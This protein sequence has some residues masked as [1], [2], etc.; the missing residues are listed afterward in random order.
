[1]GAFVKIFY[2]ALSEIP[3]RYANSIHVMRMCSALSKENK[4][5]LYVPD[6]N[7]SRVDDFKFYGVKNDFKL[8]KLFWARF[9]GR[10][11]FFALSFM[12]EVFFK[13]PDLVYGRCLLACAFSCLIARVPTRYEAHA[14]I[15]K[16]DSIH[17]ILFRLMYFSKKFEKL[18]IISKALDDIYCA[19][20]YSDKN[21]VSHDGADESKMPIDKMER[22]DNKRKCVGYFGHLYSGRGIEIIVECAKRLPHVDFLIVGGVDKDI[23]LWK[24]KGGCENLIFKGFVE[25]AQVE[26]YRSCCDVLVAPYQSKVSVNNEG[27][28]SAYMSPLKIFEYMSSGLPIICSDLPVI[29]EVL[30]E[31]NSILVDPGNVESWV[32][33][34]EKVI[35]DK[36]FSE[37]LGLRAKLDFEEKYTWE[38]RAVNVLG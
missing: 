38:S 37:S 32:L 7:K 14:P 28:S 20:G 26:K 22:R 36:Y 5:T 30:N 2:V 12:L 31:G 19:A 23:D 9:K 16:Y 15:G 1:M 10:G 18:I 25:P 34:I 8:K 35:A 17:K 21:L 33:A 6:K 27:D 24:K 4:V 11:Y 29:R 3:S 13:R